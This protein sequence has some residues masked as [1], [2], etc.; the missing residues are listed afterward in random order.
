MKTKHTSLL[1]LLI[2][3][4]GI[5][6]TASASV[7][8]TSVSTPPTCYGG[9][10]G[11]INITVT[12]GTLPY[13]YNWS[14]GATI[15]DLSGLS[16]GF[17]TV[18]VHDALNASGFKQC[19]VTTGVKIIGNIVASSVCFGN[20]N[21]SLNLTIT[22]GNAPFQFL[23]NTGATTEDIS[24]LCAGIYGVDVTDANG[25]PKLITSQIIANPAITVSSANVNP[26]C[27][28]LCN[29]TISLTVTGGTP[30]FTYTWNNG[31][32]TSSLTGLCDGQYCVTVTDAQHAQNQSVFR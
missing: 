4:N 17:Y 11:T 8:I 6:F 7:I 20:C 16:T 21:G 2:A 1:A 15:E 24:G 9:N 29:G 12:G 19:H 14:N 27:H 3:L 31:S 26:T 18:T 10:N 23:W 30:P 5:F 13:T 25:C 32:T 28:G 22:N